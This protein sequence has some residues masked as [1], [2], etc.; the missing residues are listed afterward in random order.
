MVP[1]RGSPASAFIGVP[2]RELEK[3]FRGECFKQSG[4]N[5]CSWRDRPHTK[6]GGSNDQT[7]DQAW[8]V[9][10]ISDGAEH[11]ALA[12]PGLWGWRWWR[13]WWRTFFRYGPGPFLSAFVLPAFV[14]PEAVGH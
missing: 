11:C 3:S 10:N 6:A 1:Y 8:D 12:H 4:V 5:T 2:F 13:W 14:L 9:G 7:N